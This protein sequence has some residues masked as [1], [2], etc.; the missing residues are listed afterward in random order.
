VIPPPL[1]PGVA[2]AV[3]LAAGAP[4]TA[5]QEL[6]ARADRSFLSPG[7][8]LY[9]A[10]YAPA[11]IGPMSLAGLALLGD[12]AR[13]DL[14]GLGAELEVEA[15]RWSALGDA[16]MGFTTGEL[17]GDWGGW[18]VGVGRRLLAGPV[19]LGLEVRYRRLVD[20]GQSGLE[21]GLRLGIPVGRRRAGG[22][23]P[24]ATPP[25]GGR[26]PGRPEG[27]MPGP[28]G[29]SAM[30]TRA[31]SVVGV[32]LAAMGTPYLWGG[33]DANGFDC[34][35]L[36][37]YAYSRHGVS[38]PRRSADQARSGA[39]V[40]LSLAALLP[41]DILAFAAGD[42]VTHVGL[43]VGAGRFIHSASTGVR[44]SMLDPRDPDGRWWWQHWVGAR[45]VLPVSSA[46]AP[47]GA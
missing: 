16:A 27:P 24:P 13:S 32:A 36:V 2:L 45:R 28:A 18:S 4:S 43:Y 26:A 34:S 25:G 39:S 44:T 19:R 35:G 23:A 8:T 20:L 41:G 47:P 21:A 29:S 31:D 3:A 17:E 12:G 40:E 46:T 7:F 14:Y 33:S 1:R 22:A 5:A 42:T 15:G 6:R 38:L 30:R 9:W 10:G 11:R 37:Q